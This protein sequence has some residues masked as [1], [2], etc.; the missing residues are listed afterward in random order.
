MIFKITDIK[1]ADAFRMG[2]CGKIRLFGR[3]DQYIAFLVDDPDLGRQI[4][5]QSF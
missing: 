4:S 2:E 1:T 3:I 5:I